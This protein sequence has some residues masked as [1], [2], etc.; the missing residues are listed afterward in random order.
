MLRRHSGP[1]IPATP[2]TLY[3][4]NNPPHTKARLSSG[5]V[6]VAAMETLKQM[7][8]EKTTGSFFLHS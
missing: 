1:L 8:F 6:R 3:R 2:S 4:M 5:A 7:I